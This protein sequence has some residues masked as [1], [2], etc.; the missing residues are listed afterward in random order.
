MTHSR[1]ENTQPDTPANSLHWTN[2]GVMLVH[3][4]RRWPNITSTF[5]SSRVYRGSI[6]WS[7]DLST[8]SSNS[9][10][11]GIYLAD[12]PSRWEDRWSAVVAA[13]QASTFGWPLVSDHLWM[14]GGSRWN[15]GRRTWRS[16]AVLRN[17]TH[18]IWSKYTVLP[19]KIERFVVLY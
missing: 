5:F 19:N 18:F 2:I 1:L 6:F 9:R 13:G 4:L 8:L 11:P 17:K 7:V 15:S 12:I 14:A 3:R 16:S 10:I